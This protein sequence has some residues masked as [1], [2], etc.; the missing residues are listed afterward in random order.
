MEQE[1]RESK[2]KGDQEMMHRTEL[3]PFELG[4]VYMIL[5]N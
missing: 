3:P 4:V 5:D 1:L 2:E